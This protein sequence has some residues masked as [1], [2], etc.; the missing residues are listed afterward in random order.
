MAP[1]AQPDTFEYEIVATNLIQGHGYTY[2]SPDGGIYVASQSSPLY[3]L[4]T[5]DVYAISDH[6][7]SLMLVVQVLLGGLMAG[8]TAWL[9]MRVL[10]ARR[11]RGRGC[12]GRDRPGLG[13]LRVRVA[14]VDA[15]CPGHP[16][17]GLCDD[18]PATAPEHP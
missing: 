17:K 3:I 10:F 4:I 13:L 6:S 5:A 15:R 16:C 14:L 7:Q 9:G 1:F 8:L 11:G 18:R 2:A 12:A